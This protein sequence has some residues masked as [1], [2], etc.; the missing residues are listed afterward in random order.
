MGFL[1]HTK[2]HP[3]YQIHFSMWEWGRFLDL[4][5]WSNDIITLDE[6]KESLTKSNLKESNAKA[7]QLGIKPTDFDLDEWTEKVRVEK[8]NSKNKSI[9][10]VHSTPDATGRNIFEGVSQTLPLDIEIE[11]K[12]IEKMVQTAAIS[13]SVFQELEDKMFYNK[14]KLGHLYG[15]QGNDFDFTREGCWE[16]YNTIT[17]LITG[18]IDFLDIMEESGMPSLTDRPKKRRKSKAD[19]FLKADDSI[20]GEYIPIEML[21]KMA[22]LNGI[23]INGICADQQV[24]VR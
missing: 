20:A 1:I 23:V 5:L 22:R 4:I 16:I 6:L 9:I 24:I 21:G 12:D 2:E 10:N 18:D 7:E 17:S 19:V 3:E 14:D 13:L 15:I 11:E 8:G